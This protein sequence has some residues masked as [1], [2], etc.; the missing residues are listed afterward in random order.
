[1]SDIRITGLNINN[2]TIKINYNSPTPVPSPKPTPRPTPVPS[3]DIEC[4]SCSNILRTTSLF[5]T[6]V[7]DDYDDYFTIIKNYSSFYN[8]SL[9]NVQYQHVVKYIQDV[10]K[11][12]QDSS[13]SHITLPAFGSISQY[14]YFL[15]YGHYGLTQ[16]SVNT[17]TIKDTILQDEEY[18]VTPH[19]PRDTWLSKNNNIIDWTCKSNNWA[20]AQF[21]CI[22]DQQ[23]CGSCWANAVTECITIRLSILTGYY[24]PLDLNEFINCDS[25][26]FGCIGG[27][28][29]FGM[30]YMK[31]PGL[32]GPSCN[33]TTYMDGSK[34]NLQDKNV[35]CTTSEY[36]VG[37][38]SVTSMGGFN[39]RSTWMTY[40]DMPSNYKEILIKELVN[41]PIAIVI[42]AHGYNFH[43]YSGGCYNWV[44][45]KN[46]HTTGDISPTH[47]VLLV[48]YIKCDGKTSGKQNEYWK[49]QNSWE[50]PFG[51]GGFFYVAA[52]DGNDDFDSI[53]ENKAYPI[54]MPTFCTPKFIQKPVKPV[55]FYQSP[56]LN[57]CCSYKYNSDNFILNQSCSAMTN[58]NNYKNPPIFPKGIPE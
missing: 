11:Y 39:D 10:L 40:P 37:C 51:D 33:N 20:G 34:C 31:S 14:N 38:S 17:L 35:I 57:N 47:A 2:S 29:D 1:M 19:T 7:S 48:G 5:S 16:S 41:G 32:H 3:P 23:S 53:D 6:Y 26:N 49:I 25:S 22:N 13:I 27:T 55:S 58:K 8:I 18:T 4:D 12:I 36:K 15:E 50:L 54:G 28:I 44:M 52:V 56:Y 46:K 9:T 24:C 30:F 21:T 45:D 42:W 43:S